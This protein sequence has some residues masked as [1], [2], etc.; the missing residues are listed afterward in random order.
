[1]LA[2]CSSGPASVADPVSSP[3]PSPGPAEVVDAPAAPAGAGVLEARYTLAVEGEEV[4]GSLSVEVVDPLGLEGGT[5]QLSER[6]LDLL[7]DGS[8]L[9]GVLDPSSRA[10]IHAEV[11]SGGRVSRWGTA[12]ALPIGEV[13]P[14]DVARGVLASGRAGQ[15]GEAARASFVEFAEALLLVRD[16][17]SGQPLAGG[18]ARA[19]F[20]VLVL[21]LPGEE[22]PVVRTL[23]DL[24]FAL[25]AEEA[26]ADAAAL[27]DGGWHRPSADA[28]WAVPRWLRLRERI[29]Q[30][31]FVDGLRKVVDAGAAGEP[32]GLDQVAEAF[33]EEGASFVRSWLRGPAGPLV[34]TSWRVDTGGGRLLVRVDQLQRVVPGTVAAYGFTLP[35][36]VVTEDGREVV[37]PLAVV[38]RKEL[39]QVPIDGEAVSVEFDPE[40]TL[41]GLVKLR[42]ARDS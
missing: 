18:A 41:V 16:P 29:G 37:R 34:E 40:G 4:T 28:E 2:A 3:V 36:R 20:G 21:P 19:W 12:R 38:R 14:R 25:H 27:V 9:P 11:V 17:L 26:P 33:G 39:F 23:A 7:G 31:A 15:A 1:M 32:Q 42:P 5:R 35:I 22:H 6:R 24:L 8:W 10:R 30:E 13:D